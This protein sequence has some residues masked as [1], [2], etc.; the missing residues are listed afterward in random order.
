MFGMVLCKGLEEHAELNEP[1]GELLN[2]LPHV[3]GC[4]TDALIIEPMTRAQFDPPP[5]LEMLH[6]VVAEILLALEANVSAEVERRFDEFVERLWQRTQGNWVA[7][8]TFVTVLDQ[9]LGP[10]SR[11]PRLLTQK[12]IDDVFDQLDRVRKLW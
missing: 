10:D 5:E 4:C 3:K 11:R 6:S 9:R 7:L 2:A 12:I 8:T 1:F